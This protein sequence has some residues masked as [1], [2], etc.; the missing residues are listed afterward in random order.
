M[1]GVTDKSGNP[2]TNGYTRVKNAMF[3]KAYQDENLLQQF[4]ESNEMPIKN[5][6]TAMQNAALFIVRYNNAVKDGAAFEYPISQVIVQAAK[7]IMQARA[8]ARKSGSKVSDYIES[9]SLFPQEY[10]WFTNEIALMMDEFKFKPKAMGAY[11]TRIVR[12][13]QLLGNPQNYTIFDVP[14]PTLKELVTAS[15]GGIELDAANEKSEEPVPVGKPDPLE[16]AAPRPEV[17][18]YWKEEF[19]KREQERKKA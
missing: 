1:N 9:N 7:T 11:L 4:T 6:F 3:A 5:V 18:R 12:N 19:K 13:A 2:A 10:Q 15:K 14:T 8:L 16:Q 17:V